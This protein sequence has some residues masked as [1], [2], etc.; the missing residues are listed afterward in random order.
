MVTK[1]GQHPPTRST[2]GPRPAPRRASHAGYCYPEQPGPLRR[3]LDEFFAQAEAQPVKPTQPA[4]GSGVFRALVSPHIDPLR[5]GLSYARGY[6]RLAQ[7]S[8][9][10]VLVIVGTAHRPLR[11]WFSVAREDFQTPLGLVRTDRR[12]IDRLARHLESSVA[13]RTIDLFADAAVQRIEHSIE[14]QA[15]LLQYVLGTRRPFHIVPVLAASLHEFIEEGSHPDRSPEIQAF[16]AALRAVEADYPGRVGY[17]CAADLAHVG[18]QFGDQQPVTARRRAA[19]A[20]DDHRLLARVCRCDAA[21]LFRH[22]A[23]QEDRNRICGLS[24]LYVVLQ[25]IGSARGELLDYAQSVD[26]AGQAC[27]SYATVALYVGRD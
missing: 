14:F 6:R 4:T 1:G 12:F 2:P 5:G 13:G 3:Q 7:Q 23:G 20:R 21:G 19:V 27:V 17:I 11:Q 8:T 26:P 15:V 24:P 10:D 9:A 16:L 22:V 25:A 18:P